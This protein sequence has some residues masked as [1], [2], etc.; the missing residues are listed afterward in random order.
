[1]ERYLLGL[2]QGT[3]GLRWDR[4]R[5]R[6]TIGGYSHSLTLINRIIE[7]FFPE[8]VYMHLS[9]PSKNKVLVWFLVTEGRFQTALQKMRANNI[10]VQSVTGFG[11]LMR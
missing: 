10:L 3:V 11:R 6:V 2:D 4:R 1:M 8:D 9:S 7:T 5:K